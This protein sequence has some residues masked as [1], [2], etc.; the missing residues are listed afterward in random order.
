M[1]ALKFIALYIPIIFHVLIMNINVG[2]NTDV[3]LCDGVFEVE[4]K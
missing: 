1:H 4:V 3:S 2:I